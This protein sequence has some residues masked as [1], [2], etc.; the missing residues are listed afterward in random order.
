AHL[1]ADWGIDELRYVLCE[2]LIRPLEAAGED[3]RRR[4]VHHDHLGIEPQKQE[5]FRSVGLATTVGRLSPDQMTE[6]AR[7]AELYGDRRIRLAISQNAILTG[8]PIHHLPALLREPLLKELSPSPSPFFRRMVACTGT[9]YC[10]LAQ[11][12]TKSYAVQISRALDHKL[13]AARPP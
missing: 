3:M 10:T 5:A 2:R 11:I 7:L 1:I 12:D 6:M 8:V 9:D 4:G 13:G